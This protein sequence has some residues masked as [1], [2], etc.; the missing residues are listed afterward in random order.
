MFWESSDA[1][2]RATILV[3]S[4]SSILFSKSNSY[5]KAGLCIK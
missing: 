4:L 3:A 2:S 5:S 1:E